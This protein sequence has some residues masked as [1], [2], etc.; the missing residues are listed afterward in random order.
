MPYGALERPT[1]GLSL[2]K[3]RLTQAGTA[4]D[5]RYLTFPFAELIGTE[6]YQWMTYELPYTAFAGDWSF[7]ECLYGARPDADQRYVDEVLC[8]S[9]QLDPQTVQR[10]LHI[11]SLVPAFLD[12]C[13]AAVPW[14]RYDAVGFT[15]TFEQNIA[16]LALASRL[17]AAYPDLAILFGGANW[18]GEMGLELHRRFPFVD[19]VC[20]GEADE[21]LPALLEHVLAGEPTNQFADA[22]PGIVYRASGGRSVYT[23]PAQVI[24]DLDRLP[25]PDFSDY[26][27]ALDQSPVGAVVMPTLLME[28]SRGCWW[29]AKHHCTFCGLNG[30]TMAFRSKSAE[31]AHK[32]LTY[33]VDHWRI[34]RVEVV[35][36]ILDMR[37][38]KDLLPTLA[39][40]QRPVELFYEVKANLTRQQ[41]SLLRDAGVRRIQ[42]GIES[43]SDH[44]LRLMRK[45]TTALQ[46][47]Q[48]LKWCR[49]Y[50]VTAEWN[51]L[52]GFPGETEDDYAR[53]LALLPAIR[54]LKP[55][56]ACGP[57][58]LDRFSP[59]YEEPGAFG[60][61]NIRPINAYQ[62]LYPF[63]PDIQG[64]IAYYFDFDYRPDVDPKGHAQ[65]VIEYVEEWRRA[66]ETGSLRSVRRPNDTLA[67]VDTR[68]DASLSELTLAGLE[69]AAYEFC[70][71]QRSGASVAE[72]LREIDPAVPFTDRQ[73][74]DFL[75]SMVANR[76]MVTDGKHYLGL[77]L[78]TP[79]ATVVV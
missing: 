35:D 18:E 43:L 65:A 27:E 66:P 64:R 7:T 2:L 12:H 38:F 47:I 78:A 10:V 14:G 15:S 3:A 41:V 8:R 75:E 21:T 77:A 23:G 54:F 40:E 74:T 9:W 68:A 42:P 34:D 28:T 50:G 69:R 30:G 19:Y 39:H 72:H 48:L 36:N 57:V 73:V 33:L 61:V 71:T 63:D 60:L 37:Y 67:L 58:R 24:N 53:L 6:L 1:L 45:G 22:I 20:S 11:R 44:V 79:N 4:C 49:E 70:D 26:F 55:P 29:G 51:I 17:K 13:K 16:S 25:V 56:T 62:F 76:L 32:E 52:Y 59:Y 31:R 5:V 46:N